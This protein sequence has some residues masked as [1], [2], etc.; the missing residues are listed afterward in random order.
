LQNVQKDQGK[1]KANLAY[2]KKINDSIRR[3]VKSEK[4]VNNELAAVEGDVYLIKTVSISYEL[5]GDI[6]THDASG[7]SGTGFLLNDGRFVSALHVVKPWYFKDE[8]YW[9]RLNGLETAGK[10]VEL[11]LQ[12]TSPNGKVLNFTSRDF[13]TNLNNFGREGVEFWEGNEYVK[14]IVRTQNNNVWKGDWAWTQTNE[15]GKIVADP[16]LS[17]NLQGGQVIYTLGYSYGTGGQYSSTPNPLLGKT[18][19]AQSGLDNGII[20]S[21]GRVIAPGNSGGPTF[22]LDKNG[23]LKAVG[24]VSYTERDILS[25]FVPIGSMK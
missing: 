18:T 19:V 6:K 3:V 23:K 14:Y 21:T 5:D 7:I 24:I 16:D 1:L 11:K 4:N 22:V 13:N 9:L 25:G 15:K 20:R 12:A 2:Q 10:F 8:Q 17:R